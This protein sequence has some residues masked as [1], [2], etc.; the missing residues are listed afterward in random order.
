MQKTRTSSQK[1]LRISGKESLNCWTSKNVSRTD[2]Q[3][4][5]VR[6]SAAIPPRTTIVETAAI[7]APRRARARF[8]AARSARRS[9]AAS[10]VSVSGLLKD[11]SVRSFAHPLLLDVRQFA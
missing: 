9:V 5:L 10:A 7:V 1:A 2:G 8:A 3:P 11:R 6:M 4:G